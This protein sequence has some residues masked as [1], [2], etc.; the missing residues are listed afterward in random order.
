MD[1]DFDM[2]EIFNYHDDLNN[3]NEFESLTVPDSVRKDMM[4]YM[5]QAINIGNPILE[6]NTYKNKA[7]R[8]A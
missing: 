3:W 6:Y 4:T 5:T 8:F 2:I 1:S 7:M